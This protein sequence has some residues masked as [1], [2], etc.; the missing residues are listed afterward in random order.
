[1]RVLEKSWRHSDERY[2]MA[3]DWMR[4][5]KKKM[6]IVMVFAM[7]AW[8]IGY[9]ASFLIPQKPIGTIMGEKITAEEFNDAM[10]R[11]HRVFLRQEGLP[12]DKLVW[13]QLTLV[14][15]AERMG[16]AVSNGEVIERISTLGVTMLGS[17]N[18]PPNQIVRLLCQ[19][20]TVTEEQLLRTYKEALLIEKMHVL[21]S[22]SVKVPDAEAWEMYAVD[23]EEV[24][25]EFV[26][27]G[28]QDIAKNV[29]V[30]EE[31]IV[32]FY[33]A[34]KDN[35]PD[36]VQGIPGYRE[37][38]KIKI[39][40]LMARYRDL[41]RNVTVTEDEMQ[42][43]YEKNKDRK[44]KKA[45][46][47]KGDKGAGAKEPQP[48]QYKP[49][50]EVKG[51]IK[52]FLERNKSK[53]LVDKLINETD[54]RIY[55]SLGRTEQISFS[56]IGGDL[57][58]FYKESGYFSREEAKDV[59]R[60]ADEGV[61]SKFF[62][63][64]K[65]DPSPP[66]DAPAGKFVFQVVDIKEPS[67]PPLEAVRE[68]VVKDLKEEKALAKARELA[69]QC[70]EKA[71][72]TSFE[73]G[74]KL[75]ENECKGISFVKKETEFFKR[76]EVK[77]GKLHRYINA[78]EADVPNVARSAFRLRQGELDTV[79]EESG[80]KA[81][82]VIRLTEKKEADRKKFEEK[83]EEAMRKY[84]SEKQRYFMDRWG[85]NIKKKAELTKK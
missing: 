24:K 79:V 74:I 71:K 73:E 3:L 12:L 83:K 82:Y 17:P 34:H 57:G 45:A 23:N 9:S 41:E 49:F 15:E 16:I 13:E 19:N 29:S 65:Y 84:L 72:Q 76:P 25:I 51:E 54:E 32:S 8:G 77:D 50:E 58:V 70:A 38:E 52:E 33:N 56:D 31:E 69:R 64:E 11:W 30:M 44:Y 27:I 80:R 20:Y 39:E 60:D 47:P 46:A 35:L 78:V 18:M 40:Y 28:A 1:M 6:Y 59:I 85:E 66:L 22:D 55:G 75:L 36:P 42:T 63:R 53:E 26:A 43:Y 21:L 4:R 61:Y 81:A 14:K 48:P 37:P 68:K 67:A 10:T 2:P 7:A 5:N 62:E